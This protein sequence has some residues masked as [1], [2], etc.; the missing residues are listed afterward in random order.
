[1]D[2]I[3]VYGNVSNGLE[4]QE[5]ASQ[6]GQGALAGSQPGEVGFVLGKL[7]AKLSMSLGDVIYLDVLNE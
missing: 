5:R 3:F 2:N 4:G 6:Y 7:R 1:M